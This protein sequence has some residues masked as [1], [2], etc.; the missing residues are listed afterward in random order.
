MDPGRR[1]CTGT[2]K[3][4]PAQ[5]GPSLQKAQLLHKIH[6][7]FVCLLRL[8][9]EMTK[10]IWMLPVRN[11]RLR[12]FSGS[13]SRR[14]VCDISNLKNECICRFADTYSDVCAMVALAAY[15]SVSLMC[16]F[17]Q[18]WACHV[19]YMA[20]IGAS[21][22]SHMTETAFALGPFAMGNELPNHEIAGCTLYKWF[23]T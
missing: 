23:R 13:G 1:P 4:F 9:T 5:I 18:N 14:Q 12:K 16:Y 2:P 3:E 22:C 17:A 11:I 10:R 19:C 7:R 15:L 8:A 6:I 21:S 20:L